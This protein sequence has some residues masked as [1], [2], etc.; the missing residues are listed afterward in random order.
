V[1]RDSGKSEL[2]KLDRHPVSIPKLIGVTQADAGGDL[3]N[4]PWVVPCLVRSDPCV[5]KSRAVKDPAWNDA[6]RHPSS[7]FIR[8]EAYDTG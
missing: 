4:I 8:I 7:I 2:R 6:D 1:R 3:D 5:T